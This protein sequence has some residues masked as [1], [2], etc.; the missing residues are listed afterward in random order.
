ME[1]IVRYENRKYYSKTLS[2][3]VDLNY[4]LDLAKTKQ[5][6]QVVKFADNKDI[7]KKV[8]Q[9]CLKKIDLNTNTMLSLIRGEL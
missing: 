8:L 3:Y 1:I 4:M 2:K 7:T 6:F 5:K 9:D